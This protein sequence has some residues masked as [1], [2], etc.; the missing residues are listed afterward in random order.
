MR[1]LLLLVLAALPASPA[2]RTASVS[3]N[4]SNPVTW[5]GAGAPDAGDTATINTGVTVTMDRNVTVGNSGNPVYG[6]VSS[7]TASGCSGFT[8]NPSVSF[9]GTAT[10]AG[11]GA[12]ATAVQTG[13]TAVAITLTNRGWY[14]SL[15]GVSAS[16]SGGAG[17][18]ST[19]TTVTQTGGG[20][21]AIA[22]KG[23]GKLAL[24][25]GYSLTLRG[26]M[27]QYAQATDY[28]YSLVL[29]G[30]NTITFDSSPAANNGD[31]VKPIYG[32]GAS[33]DATY[34]N[35][36]IDASAC[37]AV[38]PCVWT[39]N[40]AGGGNVGYLYAFRY[41]N[42]PLMKLSYTTVSNM[43]DRSLKA[44]DANPGGYNGWWMLDH[45]NFINCGLVMLG[46]S[47]PDYSNGFSQLWT[48]FV[49][50]RFPGVDEYLTMTTAKASYAREIKYNYFGQGLSGGNVFI[51][52][53]LLRD[54]TLTG[55]FFEHLN[56]PADSYAAGWN[57]GSSSKP[58]AMT[59]NLFRGQYAGGG[60]ILPICTPLLD[61]NYL[62]ADSDA[63]NP[64]YATVD[65]DVDQVLTY[66]I[67]EASGGD[68][69]S[70]T[71]DVFLLDANPASVRTYTMTNNVATYAPR[72][73]PLNS[74]LFTIFGPWTNYLATVD[75][76]T[77]PQTFLVAPESTTAMPANKLTL[78]SNSI[79]GYPANHVA[80]FKLWS[81]WHGCTN[82]CVNAAS[83]D[84]NYGIGINMT[85]P[86]YAW[87][88]QA[89]GYACNFSSGP[90]P[91]HGSAANIGYRD[92]E[93]ADPRWV[94]SG[95]ATYRGIRSW[96]T[97][98]LG[99]PIGIRWSNTQGTLAYGAIRSWSDPAY[100]GNQ[101][102]N[103]R[104][105]RVGG[106]DT[107]AANTTPLTG[108]A[109]RTQW[110]WASLQ[111]L[112]DAMAAGS[113]Y[114]DGAIRCSGCS[115]VEALWSWVFYGF[116]PQNPAYWGSG[117]DGKDVGAVHLPAAQHILPAVVL[118]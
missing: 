22:L 87:T 117:H 74:D 102:R 67:A 108:S 29:S 41:A 72:Q 20:T 78:R 110:E 80:A 35:N 73:A 95:Y 114:T 77:W 28:L 105:I 7:V 2:A 57:C 76:N 91:G 21:A 58:S 17:T 5:G 94:S 19:V 96:D 24:G 71:G 113:T 15:T 25:A 14:S 48:S 50:G 26:D 27:V 45:V 51:G 56:A 68:S 61:H 98:Y 10:Y 65:K 1:G 46:A 18:C 103:V 42:A 49:G 83:C 43:G 23:T 54:F 31:G 69:G 47:P 6:Y 104:C 84:Y 101:P 39:A 53:G 55:N 44:F 109:W 13:G 8:S 59:W 40:L 4:W 85:D 118:P 32:F 12:S 52:A 88:N 64:H 63:N 100:D 37:T 70:D 3:G 34:R 116:T 89:I 30:G 93:D 82:V 111:Y 16:L 79:V 38:A 90:V 106:C 66:N 115:A 33:A 112:R 86:N 62:L 107:S 99:Q 11:Q 60:V 97:G 75:H 36:G 9:G 92:R 81:G